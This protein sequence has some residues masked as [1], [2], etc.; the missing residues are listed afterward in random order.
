MT[1][2][3]RCGP[4]RVVAGPIA[5]LLLAAAAGCVGP[6]APGE[7][8]EVRNQEEAVEIIWE[9]ALGREDQPPRVRWVFADDQTCI[10]GHSGRGGFDT[11]VGC[12]EG[13]TVSPF[14]VTVSWVTGGTFSDTTLAHEL[15]HAAQARSLVFD[16]DHETPAFQPG[17]E[18]D[19]ANA[20]LLDAG[21]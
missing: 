6:L 8:V 19:Q 2:G 11:V 21:L 5:G 4:G 1:R 15:V 16:R 14:V 7:P 13:L 12:V 10:H 9:D 3:N 17:G 20:M 18:V